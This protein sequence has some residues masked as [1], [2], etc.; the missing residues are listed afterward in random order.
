M[1]A[2]G[3]D[4]VAEFAAYL[5]LKLGPRMTAPGRSETIAAPRSGLSDAMNAASR[6]ERLLL[7]S[8]QSPGA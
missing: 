5:P 4:R 1:T 2:G 8:D 6:I 3:P 7:P